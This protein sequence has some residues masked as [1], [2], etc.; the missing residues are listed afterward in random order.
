MNREQIL[1]LLEGVDDAYIAEA[2]GRHSPPERKSTMKHKRV[3]TLALAAAFLL[4][5]GAV[6]YAA[7]WIGPKAIVLEGST[8]YTADKQEDGKLI[9]TENPAGGQVSLTQ[10]QEEPE[11]LDPDILGQVEASRAA[12]EEWEIYLRSPDRGPR[13]PDAFQMPEGAF[14]SAVEEDENGSLSVVFFGPEGTLE[15][16]PVTEAECEAYAAIMDEQMLFKSKYDFNYSCTSRE[17]EL[18]LEALAAKYG[19]HLRGAGQV[20][21]SADT[22]RTNEA[23]LNEEHGVD[24]HND[25]SGPQ[26]L[27]DEDLTAFIAAQCCRGPLFYET[28][29]GYDKFY[30][31]DDGGFGLSWYPVFTRERQVTCYLYSAVYGSLSSGR[32]VVSTVEDL[33]SFSESR[34]RCPDGTELT[35]LQSGTDVYF[36]TYLAESYLCGHIMGPGLSEA[37]LDNAL[38]AIC[39]SNI[40]K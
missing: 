38:D 14:G 35:V 30:Y 20:L 18:A 2:A 8:A 37:E 3:I 32:E 15:R 13:L 17:D 5:L 27:S 4:G 28:P 10:P 16:R 7:G 39:W 24:V 36:Y 34:H 22:C 33:S 11:D 40:G 12:W 31:F 6:A 1:L 26:F 19:L 21:W 25:F 23:W 9:W 29:A